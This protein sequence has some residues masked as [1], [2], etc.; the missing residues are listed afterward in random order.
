MK[1]KGTIAI[2]AIVLVMSSVVGEA[3][4]NPITPPMVVVATPQNNHVYPQNS[5]WLNFTVLPIAIK[6]FNFSSFSYSLDGQAAQTT[7]G[8]TLLTNLPSG[9]HTLAIYGKAGY[10]YWK[11]KDMLLDVLYFSTNYSTAWV[12]FIVV[13]LATSVPMSVGLFVNRRAVAG[14][15]R[16]K[17]TGSFWVGLACFL[18]FAVFVFG[19]SIWQ[20]TNKYLF[21]LYGHGAL[22]IS[23]V[24]GAIFGLILMVV[25]FLLMVMGTRQ[26]PD[27][28]D[29]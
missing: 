14:R 12:G 13:L 25:G 6:D 28:F 27:N 5:V 23:T 20:L 1:S 29:R 2:L 11:D 16:Q 15:L 7:D 21:P 24:P 22:A 18:F 9:S 19:P 8:A 4:A 17:K 3:V 26:R 10:G